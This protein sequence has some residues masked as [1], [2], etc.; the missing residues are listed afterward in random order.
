MKISKHRWKCININKHQWTSVKKRWLMFKLGPGSPSQAALRRQGDIAGPG[1]LDGPWGTGEVEKTSTLHHRSET[2]PSLEYDNQFFLP[3]DFHVEI[4]LHRR[5]FV[6][7]VFVWPHR[8]V[9]WVFGEHKMN[10]CLIMNS[11]LQPSNYCQSCSNFR[12]GIGPIC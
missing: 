1:G 11:L 2:K 8:R 12:L 3:S 4:F 10:P 5:H 6:I 9:K 7:Q